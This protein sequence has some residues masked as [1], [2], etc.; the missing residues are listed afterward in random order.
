MLR[1][2]PSPGHL[3]GTTNRHVV[4]SGVDT[5]NT[6]AAQTQGLPSL[7]V[8]SQNIYVCSLRCDVLVVSTMYIYLDNFLHH[9]LT[10]HLTK[11]GPVGKYSDVTLF[12]ICK[13]KY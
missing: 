10:P 4:I 11:I 8:D 2:C 9:V 13:R 12:D 1:G 3:N 6:G 7:V 5:V